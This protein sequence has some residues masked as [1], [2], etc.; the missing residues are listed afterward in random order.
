[1]NFLMSGAAV[2]VT[3]FGVDEVIVADCDG[4]DL[5]VVDV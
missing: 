3:S 5:M 2:T 1:M 4:V